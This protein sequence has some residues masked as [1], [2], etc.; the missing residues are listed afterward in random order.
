MSLARAFSRALLGINAPLVTVETHI[1]AGLPSLAIVGMP[2]TAVRESKERVRSAII[3]SNLEFPTRRLTVNLAPA[4]LP[5]AGG[6][7]DLAIAL[8]ILQA[9]GQ[10]PA[11]C[12][13]KFEFLGELALNGELRGVRGTLPA[14]IS[15]VESG[16]TLLVPQA[17]ADEVGVVTQCPAVQSANLLEVVAMLTGR[18]ELPNC[19]PVADC[20]KKA[21]PRVAKFY[22]SIKGQGRAKRALLLAAAG[23]HNLLLKGPPGTGKTLLANAL[24]EILPMP[25]ES[26][27]LQVAAIQ[28]VCNARLP[29][30]TFGETPVRSPHH[31]TTPVAMAGG[32]QRASP[33]EVSLAHLGVLFLD[34]LPEFSARTLQVLREP[35]ESGSISISRA[36]YSVSF[37]ARFQLVAAMNPCPCG[38]YGDSSG[39]CHCTREQVLGYLRKVSGPLQDRMDLIVEVPR[40]GLDELVAEAD[41]ALNVRQI[42][43]QISQCRQLQLQRAG[44]LNSELEPAEIEKYCRLNQAARDLVRQATKRYYLSGRGLHR[45]LKLARTIADLEK[46]TSLHEQHILE[47]MAYRLEDASTY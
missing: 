17:N 9:S 29:A 37:P 38:F 40:L 22:P 41:T 45:V 7:Y 36:S 10:L 14:A 12:L 32:G 30:Q 39:M 19:Q 28:S 47:A 33:G 44:K 20:E 8:S 18:Q 5:K 21:Q 23:R 11:D 43:Q 31:T 35:L 16:R 15:M 46:V 27:A 4:D 34:E 1:S 13:L 25:T 6:R 24:A 42:R 3:N 2:E 26:D